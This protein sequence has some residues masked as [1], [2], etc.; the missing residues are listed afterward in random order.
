MARYDLTRV[1]AGG[2]PPIPPPGAANSGFNL[3]NPN[4]TGGSGGMSAF[5]ALAQAYSGMQQYNGEYD[6]PAQALCDMQ[7]LNE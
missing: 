2:N 7:Q 5:D 4:P 6:V 1:F 3:S